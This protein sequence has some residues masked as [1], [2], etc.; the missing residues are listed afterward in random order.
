M[1]YSNINTIKI[2]LQ[3]TLEE[4]ELF[5]SKTLNNFWKVTRKFFIYFKLHCAYIFL[6]THEHHVFFCRKKNRL[7][8]VFPIRTMACRIWHVGHKINRSYYSKNSH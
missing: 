7:V 3:H 5:K 2:L 6:N 8:A 4:F 1:F